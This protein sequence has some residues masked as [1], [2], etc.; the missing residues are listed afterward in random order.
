L[1]SLYAS[2]SIGQPTRNSGEAIRRTLANAI[3]E[4]EVTAERHAH[5][6]YSSEEG[7]P[8][9]TAVPVLSEHPVHGPEVR[10]WV[11]RNGTRSTSP[12]PSTHELYQRMVA[13]VRSESGGARK[14]SQDIARL[15]ELEG[16]YRHRIEQ[17]QLAKKEQAARQIAEL[18]EVVVGP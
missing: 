16:S 9:D 17:R 8:D 3:D 15:G 2:S 4:A 7:P 11:T 18:P 14:R 12:R 10:A 1:G 5:I 6:L 13:K